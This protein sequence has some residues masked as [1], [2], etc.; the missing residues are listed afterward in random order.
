MQINRV[1]NV[2]YLPETVSFL[3]TQPVNGKQRYHVA[4]CPTGSA[5][6]GFW[7]GTT[8]KLGRACHWCMGGAW[9]FGPVLF[10]L[11]VLEPVMSL[12][13]GCY[14]F[15]THLWP[16]LPVVTDPNLS[17]AKPVGHGAT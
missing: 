3:N 2:C 12:M 8:G 16:S 17:P 10:V 13:D 9:H 7:S 5:G 15:C 11:G 6:P 14:M 4:P 1:K